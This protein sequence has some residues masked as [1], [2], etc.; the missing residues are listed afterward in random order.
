MKEKQL[1]LTEMPRTSLGYMGTVPRLDISSLETPF[2][3]LGVRYGPPYVPTDLIEASTAPDAIRRASNTMTPPEY[4]WSR[5]D[6]DFE[7]PMFTGSPTVTDVGDVISDIRNLD[8]VFQRTTQATRAI[9]DAGAV[10]LVQGG[11]DSIP[12]LVL[13]AFDSQPGRVN[14]LQ[15]DAHLDYRDE[16]DGI[17]D[18]YSSPMR[19]IREMPWV[20][21]IVQVG[22]R[23]RG[24]AS[25][26][27]VEQARADGNIIFTAAEV[28]RKGM[29]PVLDVLRSRERWIITLDCDGLDPSVAPGVFAKS[30]GGLQLREVF[31]LVSQLSREDRVAGMICTEFMPELDVAS[32]TALNLL[33]IQEALIVPSPR[34]S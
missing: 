27:E 28:H 20:D 18:G 17:R 25:I 32:T 5:Y 31:E 21:T 24:S 11:L 3:F 9:L 23:G 10:P 14:V 13:Q 34:N 6:F 2:A 15:I 7:R 33:R 26:E 1:H 19:R 29:V 22:L 4:A 16:I 8:A 30:P 12:P